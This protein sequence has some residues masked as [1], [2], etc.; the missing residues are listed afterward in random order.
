MKLTNRQYDWFKKILIMGVPAL[1]TLIA[2]L[3][4]LYQLDAQMTAL[5]T[6]TISL[7]ATFA[8]VVLNM[9]SNEY[10]KDNESSS[11]EFKEEDK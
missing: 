1:I 9:I 8:G 4:D 2:G 10:Q 5:I 7:I 3:G 11:E 6:G